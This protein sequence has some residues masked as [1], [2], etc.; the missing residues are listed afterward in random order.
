M[1]QKFAEV[2]LLYAR[3]NIAK[4]SH[5]LRTRGMLCTAGALGVRFL[6]GVPG[7]LWYSF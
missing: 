3:Q 6:V 5:K 4:Q 7:E 1:W 2:P